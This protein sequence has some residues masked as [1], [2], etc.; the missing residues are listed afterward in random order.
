MRRMRLDSHIKVGKIRFSLFIMQLER[1][2]ERRNILTQRYAESS[3]REIILPQNYGREAQRNAEE[4]RRRGI[5][6]NTEEY[7]GK[8]Y[9]GK[10]Y[11]GKKYK[12]I[13]ISAKLLG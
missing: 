8:K 13:S 3:L 12:E 10:E 6:R 11:K 7:K 5:H 1:E 9:K 2:E 4:E